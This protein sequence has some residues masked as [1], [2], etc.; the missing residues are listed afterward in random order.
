M[1]FRD[2]LQHLRATRNMT[3]EQ[4]AMLVGVSRQSV[5]K[6]EAE[7][8]YPE[9][10]KLLKLCQIFDCTLDD[11]VQG[12]LTARVPEPALAV[13]ESALDEDVVGYDE[14]ERRYARRMALGVLSCILGPASASLLDGKASD[15]IMGLTLMAFVAAG[16]WM[17]ISTTMENS[18]FKKAH[19]YVADFYTEE[20]RFAGRRLYGIQLGAG[21]GVIL[22]SVALGG[23]LDEQIVGN[24]S[25]GIF[26]FGIAAGVSF[27]VYASLMEDRFDIEGYNI[28][29]LEDLSEEEIAGIVGEERAAQVLA[30]V[31]SNKRKGAACGIIMI[32]A[33]A[34]ALSLLFWGVASDRSFW[35]SFFWLPWMIGALLCG[36]ACIWIDQRK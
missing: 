28:S 2:N 18:A 4:L 23:I 32:V 7:R 22:L 25:S 12:D 34:I 14:H 16:I 3:Q 15:G 13:P 20:Q 31:R 35:I 27:I 19:P 29:A 26:M 36:V 8:A 6:W 5:T 9:M 1:S 24:L 17:I 10:D 21:I 33:T 11:L 30:K